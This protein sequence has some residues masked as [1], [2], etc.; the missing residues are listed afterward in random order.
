MKLN[1]LVCV[2]CFDEHSFQKVS[3]Y[4]WQSLPEIQDTE[5]RHGFKERLLG[6]PGSKITTKEQASLSVAEQIT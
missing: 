2:Q 6:A 3:E 5:V 4:L 1:I